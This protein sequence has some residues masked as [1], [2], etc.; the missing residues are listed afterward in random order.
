MRNI[1]KDI[2]GTLKYNFRSIIVFELIY[3][4]VAIVLY[5][6]IATFMINYLMRSSGYSFLT[7]K[8]LGDILLN[9]ITYPIV[10]LLIVIAVLFAGYEIAVLHTGFR[11]AAGGYNM[12]IT[13]MLFGGLRRFIKLFVPKNISILFVNAVT[14]LILQLLPIR[15]VLR[16]SRRIS[17]A[18]MQLQEFRLVKTL[19]I[20]VVLGMIIFVAYNMFVP[21]FQTYGYKKDK[22]FKKGHDF[23]KG[24]WFKTSIVCIAEA[25]IYI[26]A[27]LLV[28]FIL[29]AILIFL[30]VLLAT[31]QYEVVLVDEIARYIKFVLAYFAS[32][33]SMYL[34]LGTIVA[35]FYHYNSEQRDNIVVKKSYEYEPWM[36]R[37]FTGV[38][39][40][41]AVCTIAVIADT[42]LNGNLSGLSGTIVMSHR[43]DS[44]EAPENTI[45]AVELA[46]E[47]MSDYVEIDVR[48]TKD[49][50]IVVIH[51]ADVKRTTGVDGLVK[52][53]TYGE[54]KELDAGSFFSREYAGTEIPTLE[55][56][57]E[58]CK[59]KINVNIEI[60]AHAIDSEE[61][62]K[63]ITDIVKKY[64]MEEQCIFQASSYSYLKQIKAQ[65]INLRTG[66]IIAAGIGN[67]FDDKNVDFFSINSAYISDN[68]VNMAHKSGKG[69]YAWTVNS[70]SELVR[71]KKLG[72]D[73]VITD[74]P[75]YAREVMAG[76]KE[77][78][79][80]ISYIKM[81]MN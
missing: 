57:L 3:R 42:M 29:S 38:G 4:I 45:P 55:E 5:V 36:K 73:G 37:F 63:K 69:I 13:A 27:Y 79:S 65:D 71:M 78:R 76:S 12:K 48:E 6:R 41:M 53:M 15:M 74:V 7:L 59:S 52:K 20:L 80:I 17:D 54:I 56:V 10:L 43:G 46:I 2:Y 23:W 49:G 67:Y 18:L 11:V 26:V 64:N 28:H 22:V 32:V 68:N 33:A 51:D 39:I 66:L 60:K 58:V 25:V 16:S 50:Q 14:Y 24:K 77:T 1:I 72:V 30:V 61:F 31:D 75:L 62:I 44:N 9:P 8:N 47:K 40:I 35:V 34:G 70:Y 21:C 19:M 81:H